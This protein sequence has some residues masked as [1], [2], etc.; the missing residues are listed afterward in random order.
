MASQAILV[1]GTTI[2]LTSNTQTAI[3]FTAPT[4][5]TLD[6][7][8]REL[9]IQG[10]T[11]PEIDTTSFCSTAKEFLLGLPDA[12]TMTIQG[13][14]KQGHAAHT[15]IRVAAQDK[16]TRGLFITFPDFSTIRVLFSVQQRSMSM[17]VDGVVSA[18]YTFRLTGEMV[19]DDPS[20]NP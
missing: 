19:E 12:G 18:S 3:P 2:Q 15:V 6:C 20:G 7:I 10:G 5:V 16:L 9:Q 14:W 13:F 17:A 4:Y 1:Q 8:G 11:S